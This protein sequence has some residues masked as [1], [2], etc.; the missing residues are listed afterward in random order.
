MKITLATDN[1]FWRQQ[2]GSH[3]R[4]RALVNYLAS[5]RNDLSVVFLG[6][7]Y[8]PDEPGLASLPE[9]YRFIAPFGYPL[10]PDNSSVGPLRESRLKQSAKR[11]AK[12]ALVE[13]QRVLADPAGLAG[14]SRTRWRFALQEP[15]LRDF[16][17]PEYQKAFHDICASTEP[18][19]VIVE[20]IRLGYL[21]NGLRAKLRVNAKLLID[22]N[23]VMHDRRSRFHLRGEPHDIDITPAEESRILRRF[24][25]VM[26]IQS[27]DASK[28]RALAPQVTVIVVGHPMP[29]HPSHYRSSF[30]V[31]VGFFG[32]NMPPNVDAVQ[33]LLTDII[34]KIASIFA[35]TVQFH[36]FGSVC[37]P[38][39]ATA[40]PRNVHLHGFVSDLIAAYGD[41]DIVVAPIE[42]GGGLSIKNVEALCFGKPLVTTY[43]AAEGL[44]DG[45][46]RA[47]VAAAS[48][49][50]L[51]DA[52][53]RL[54]SSPEERKALGCAAIEY[55]RSHFDENAAFGELMRFIGQ[56][57]RAVGDQRVGRP[58]P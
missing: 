34:P 53:V 22:T 16:V 33:V 3:K 6:Q 1:R 42:Y 15:K 9:N 7:L 44:E 11:F 31:N 23:D 24:D 5:G 47:F 36:V 45:I 17:R 55:A 26:A 19:V 28:L 50:E 52:L 25:A 35:D 48:T 32:S 29:L 4:I 20:Y 18:E 13:A 21:V 43:V 37:D 10:K 30:P 51:I 56:P 27:E 46:G 40:M 2:L 58:S 39:T 14:R 12:Q 57:V 8:D 41:L 38:F 54:A 49:A